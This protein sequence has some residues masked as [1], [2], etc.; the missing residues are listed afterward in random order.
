MKMKNVEILNPFFERK[1]TESVT[2][3]LLTRQ[4]LVIFLLGRGFKVISSSITIRT[5]VLIFVLPELPQ[6]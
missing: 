6:P 5:V 4:G 3:F 1:I 2:K